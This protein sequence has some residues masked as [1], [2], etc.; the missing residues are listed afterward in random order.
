MVL[1]GDI[2][3]P[4][5]HSY[6]IEYIDDDKD[7]EDS[8]L[9]MI[10]SYDALNIYLSKEDESFAEATLLGAMDFAQMSDNMKFEQEDYIDYITS[11]LS[12]EIIYQSDAQYLM[13]VRDSLNQDTSALT[14]DWIKNANTVEYPNTTAKAQL[15][16]F[17]AIKNHDLLP[18]YQG[19][20]D[21]H[22]GDVDDTPEFSSVSYG[23]LSDLLIVKHADYSVE[24]V[25]TAE[26]TSLIDNHLLTLGK[27]VNKTAF[28]YL[29]EQD[30]D[31]D[32][33]GDVNENGDG[34]V[35]EIEVSIQS[36]VVNN[37]QR[38]SI[39]DHQLQIINLADDDEFTQVKFYFVKNNELLDTASTKT[40]V[41]FG[42][43]D[44]VT[45]LNNTYTIYA[46]AN[47]DNID[48]ILAR[49]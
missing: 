48:I 46:I 27:D 41:N 22:F 24:L 17:N 10:S 38:T 4:T 33:D 15:K 7:D 43:A 9:N 14:L 8:L 39:Y 6:E 21:F 12:N 35:D 34:I 11:S 42:A 32:N 26:Q 30:V 36:L 19:D 28:F 31:N 25:S 5:I 45:L 16:V 23:Q 40:T 18:N 2:S 47:V 44:T 37:S 29:I 49:E 3:S 20:F 1:S 13:E